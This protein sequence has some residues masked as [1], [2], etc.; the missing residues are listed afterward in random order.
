M[1]KYGGYNV[2]FSEGQTAL[3]TIVGILLVVFSFAI[4]SLMFENILPAAGTGFVNVCKST[5]I[6]WYGYQILGISAKV[7]GTRDIGLIQI[8]AMLIPLGL[9]T[10]LVRVSKAS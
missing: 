5:D 10:K 6:F 4:G 1:V 8:S 3:K 2:Q 7:C 9:L